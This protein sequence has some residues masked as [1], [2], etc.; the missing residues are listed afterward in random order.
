MPVLK[1]IHDDDDKPA[2][3]WKRFVAGCLSGGI[4]R[5]FSNPFDLIKT[6][7]ASA[8]GDVRVREWYRRV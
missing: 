5:G 3:A 6:L 8:G 2:P 1:C 4:G 7:H